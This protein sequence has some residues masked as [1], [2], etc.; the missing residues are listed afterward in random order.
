MFL[1]KGAVYKRRPQK[2]AKNWP[3]PPLD[4]KMSALAEPPIVRADTID[5]EKSEIICSKKYGCPQLKNSPCA[6]WTPP[7]CGTSFMDSAKYKNL[8]RS[9]AIYWGL[10]LFQSIAV[11]W[12]LYSCRFHR[13]KFV[14]LTWRRAA[15]TFWSQR[16][17]RNYRP[18]SEVRSTW[19]QK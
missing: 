10:Y 18:P 11:Y 9:V 13:L 1:I 12:G 17:L 3:A 14:I 15:E 16:L 4:R 7:D 5:F 19:P 6:H 2:I 8:F